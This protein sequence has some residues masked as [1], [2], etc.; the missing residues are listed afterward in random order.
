MSA[1]T[2]GRKTPAQPK[3]TNFKLTAL[4]PI[5]LGIA[6]GSYATLGAAGP[7]NLSSNALEVVTAVEPNI[8]ILTDD[9][10]SMDW[11]VMTEE[12][13]GALYLDDDP[14]YYTHPD[15]LAA[16]AAPAINTDFW[17]V[18]T[19][20]HLAGEGL[21]APQGG[22]WRAWNHN[23]NKIYYNPNVTYTP[24]KGVDSAGASYGN[25]NAA[26]APYNPYDAAL[27]VLNLTAELDYF[28]DCQLPA[29][30]LILD[31]AGIFE[32]EDFYRCF[33]KS[34]FGYSPF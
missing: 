19:E 2:L 25:V 20:E 30:A 10:G 22:V 17:V 23:Y 5:C 24:W 14:Y 29:C 21:A 33:W 15:P 26:A 34:C 6:I 7:L 27:G 18:P 11:G 9:S 28:T 31:L 1:N 13:E 12:T 8:V 3:K 16:G 32:V 4:K